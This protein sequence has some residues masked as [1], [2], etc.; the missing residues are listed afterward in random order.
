MNKKDTRWSNR[1]VPQTKFFLHTNNLSVAIVR[2]A[3]TSHLTV[4][5]EH[6]ITYFSNV[7]T[8]TQA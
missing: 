6:F 1:H 3:A 4:L 7:N 2:D 8:A 5:S